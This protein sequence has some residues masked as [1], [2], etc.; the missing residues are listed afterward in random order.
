MDLEFWY[1]HRQ[2][3]RVNTVAYCPEPDKVGHMQSFVGAY[4][5]PS[6]VIPRCSAYLA[7]LDD[8]TA[9][10]QSQEAIVWSDELRS[11]FEN[12]QLALSSAHTITLPRPDD[13]LW[14]V[15]NDA[16][17]EPGLGT[18]LYVTRKG[19]LHLAGFFSAKLWGAQ[20]AWLPCEVEALSI[21]TKHF[22]PYI[23]QSSKNTCVLTD[24]KPCVQAYEKLYRGEFYASPR[25][26]TFLSVVSWYQASVRHVS[27]SAILQSDFASRNTPPCEEESCQVCSSIM[28]TKESVVQMSSV[29]DVLDRNVDFLLPAGL[30]G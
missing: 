21:R 6:H 8:A 25:V 22:S 20:T 9:S 1:P 24:S 13:Q 30:P 7:P 2:F 29:Q 26:S 15:T 3:P 10:C 23:V 4:K 28:H 27:G 11:S 17:R 12:A 14:I 16:V 18:S 5:V 19:N